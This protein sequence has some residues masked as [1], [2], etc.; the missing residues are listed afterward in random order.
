MHKFSGIKPHS[1]MS[2][3]T[4]FRVVP[5]DDVVTIELSDDDHNWHLVHTCESKGDYYKALQR[6]KELPFP[7]KP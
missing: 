3:G 5:Y 6:C 7:L 2:H 1:F 4:K